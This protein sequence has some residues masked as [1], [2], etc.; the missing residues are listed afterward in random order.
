MTTYYQ[1]V[2]NFK[3]APSFMPTFDGTQYN[4]N[5]LWNISAKRFYVNCRASDG[6]LVFMIPLITNPDPIELISLTYDEQN[7][8]VVVE[9]VIPHRLTVGMVINASI[10]GCIPIEYNGNG[11]MSVLSDTEIVYSMSQ[12][13]GQINVLGTFDYLISMTKGYFISTLIF[14]NEKFE[15]NP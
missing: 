12:N 7:S 2:P 11:F 6:T 10:A 4:I 5:I 13:P 3:R 14:R 9:T 8:R 1:F 15:V